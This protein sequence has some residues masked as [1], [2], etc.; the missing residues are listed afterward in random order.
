PLRQS[1]H[2]ITSAFHAISEH[3]AEPV[4][5][6]RAIY[7]GVIPGLMARLDP[8]SVFLDPE[9]YQLMQQQS[10]GVRQGFGAVLNVQAGRITVLQ[11][12]PDSP[13]GRAGLGPGDRIVAIN[14]QRVAMMNL[15]ELVQALNEARKGKVRLAVLQGGSVVP[16]DVEM[17]PAEVPSPTVDRQFLWG[18]G[19]GYLRISRIEPGT[20]EE[21]RKA[22]AV[23]SREPLEGVILDLRN[24]PGGSVDAAVETAGLFLPQGAAVARLQG[25][26]VPEVKYAVEAA[27]LYP[28]LPLVLLLNERS[29]SA[30][31]MIAAAFQE[32]DRA[33]L[34]GEPTF[35]K[36]VAESVLPLSGGNALILTTAR[37]FTPQGR[38]LQKPL[39]GTALAGILERGPEEFFTNHGRPVQEQGGVVPD[40]R[41]EPW[42]LEEWAEILDQTTVFINFAQR[43]VDSHR[44]ITE[45]FYVDDPL[46]ESFRRYLRE[47]GFEVS[48]QQWRQ[49]ALFLRTKL[50]AEVFNLV[51][52]I[53]KGDE[54]LLRED[55]QVLAAVAALPQARA[56]LEQFAPGTNR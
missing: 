45:Q 44:P 55:P 33:W 23:W 24:N 4:E 10:R 49:N 14:G 15:E 29:A 37:Y 3:F 46:L 11:S 54:A 8:F 13:F 53:S 17:D 16:R 30:A 21:I 25:R 5:P 41:A 12:V 34:V 22:L 2:R 35:G 18:P 47:A 19:V 48:D 42:R 36:G 50:R 26:G 56:L 38:S 6:E 52:G 31:E 43:Y 28:K 40:E 1:L 39:P 27:P 20:P 51:F 9:Q 7:H 32:H